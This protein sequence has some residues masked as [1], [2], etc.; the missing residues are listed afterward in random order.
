[1]NSFFLLYK[2]VKP[3][4]FFYVKYL[5]ISESFEGSNKKKFFK[6]KKYSTVEKLKHGTG[7]KLLY[8]TKR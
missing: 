6:L 1:M 8:G 7:Y 4:I 3:N 5:V 2:T